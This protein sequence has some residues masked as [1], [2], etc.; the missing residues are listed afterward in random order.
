MLMP[1]RTSMP[2]WTSRP[3]RSVMVTRPLG[4]MRSSSRWPH[5]TVTY[6]VDELRT[7]VR[8]SMSRTTQARPQRG[9]PGVLMLF[10]VTWVVC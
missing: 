7:L 2:T 5:P 10:L 9:V 1:S 6:T 8:P 4:P 3:M